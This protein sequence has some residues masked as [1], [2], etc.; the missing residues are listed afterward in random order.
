[1]ARNRA[2]TS[3]QERE[4]GGKRKRG[5]RE[6]RGA[7]EEEEEGRD[8]ERRRELKARCFALIKNNAPPLRNCV[9]TPCARALMTGDY[10]ATVGREVNDSSPSA[11]QTRGVVGNDENAADDDDVSAEST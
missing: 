9:Y 6:R 5:E 3:E 4:K 2:R 8:R 10:G 11:R 1:M 7:K